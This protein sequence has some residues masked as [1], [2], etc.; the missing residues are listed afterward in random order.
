[1]DPL[2]ENVADAVVIAI[3]LVSGL[4]AFA[5]GFVREILVVGAWLGAAFATLYLFE[6]LHPYLREFITLTFMADA[7]TGVGSF[8]IT[9][10]LLSLISHG[11][12]TRFRSGHIGVL[13]RALGF[14]FGLARGIVVVCIAYLVVAWFVPPSEQPAWIREARVTPLV[15]YTSNW[16][17][18]LVPESARSADA[19][20]AE[21]ALRTRYLP[22]PRDG[23]SGGQA[24]ELHP[25]PWQAMDSAP[26]WDYETSRSDSFRRA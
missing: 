7:I 22:A 15:E 19:D 21:E 8:V 11:I 24:P 6:V 26:E 23:P 2:S 25:I 16:L 17:L 14:V 20:P 18:K 5:R 3:V 12:A 13:D 4:L 9:L 10:I 1:M